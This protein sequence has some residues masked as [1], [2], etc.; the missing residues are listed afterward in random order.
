MS[1]NVSKYGQSTN[2]VC[3]ACAECE[4]EPDTA[5]HVAAG[6]KMNE[7]EIDSL[8]TGQEDENGA[9][10]Y[11]GELR[12]PACF[13]SLSDFFHTCDAK[14]WVGLFAAFVKHIMSV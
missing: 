5:P 7:T 4:L 14:G 2:R 12:F 3:L 6:E 9:V 10:H 1:L 13:S 11:E 8:M